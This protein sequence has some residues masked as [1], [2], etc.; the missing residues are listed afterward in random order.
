VTDSKITLSAPNIILNNSTNLNPS[1]VTIT[2]N[3]QITN[4]SGYIHGNNL[5]LRGRTDLGVDT[6]LTL[7]GTTISYNATTNNFNGTVRTNTIDTNTGG[8]ISVLQNLTLA[9][10]RQLRTD[11]VFSDGIR[12]YTTDLILTGLLPDNKTQTNIILASPQISL[13]NHPF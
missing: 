10:G 4:G 7:S 8:T 6:P 12:S 13:N 9:T 2:G 1:L 11:L 3:L 5:V